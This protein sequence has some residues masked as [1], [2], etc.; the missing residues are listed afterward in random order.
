M[1]GVFPRKSR[2]LRVMDVNGPPQVP[3]QVLDIIID[4]SLG[5]HSQV[6]LRGQERDGADE[7]RL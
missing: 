1:D 2:L 6:P 5:G 7:Q 3:C 4:T